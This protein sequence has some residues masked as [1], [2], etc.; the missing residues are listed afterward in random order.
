MAFA[1]AC[2]PLQQVHVVDAESASP[3]AAGPLVPIRPVR[4]LTDVRVHGPPPR[5]QAPPRG[6]PPTSPA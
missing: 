3:S 6:P 5:T 1:M 2:P 4:G